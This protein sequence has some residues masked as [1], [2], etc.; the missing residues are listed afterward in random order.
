[1]VVPSSSSWTIPSAALGLL[2]PVVVLL[3]APA[4][5]ATTVPGGTIGAD[6]L[7][8]AT[9][10][11]YILGGDVTIG[12][13]ATLS[14]EA[15][16]VVLVDGT[17]TIQI[18]GGLDAAGSASQPISFL[19]NA[20]VARWGGLYFNA[21]SLPSSLSNVSLSAVT[22]GIW[23]ESP[24]ALVSLTDVSVDNAALWGID[25]HLVHGRLEA[26]HVTLTNSLE[27]IRLRTSDNITVADLTTVNMSGIWPPSRKSFLGINASE[28]SDSS[29]TGI[30]MN[31][32]SALFM[33]SAR[34]QISGI[35]GDRNFAPVSWAG[36]DVI[37]S[38]QFVIDDVDMKGYSDG[39]RLWEVTNSTA[40]DISVDSA[41]GTG[42][43]AT[44]S[45][46]IDNAT[47]TNSSLGV[48]AEAVWGG[49]ATVRNVHVL[50]SSLGFASYTLF[51]ISN[52][53]Y[54]YNVDFTVGNSVDNV[55]ILAYYRN[56]NPPPATTGPYSWLFVYGSTGVTVDARNLTSRGAPVAVWADVQGG[57]LVNLNYTG[58]LPGLAVANAS[59]LSLRNIYISTTRTRAF[60]AD[61][62]DRITVAGSTF[63]SYAAIPVEWTRV[64][65]STIENTSALRTDFSDV[66]SKAFIFD[67]CNGLY[68]AD[69][70][71]ASPTANELFSIDGN[72]MSFVRSTFLGN[73]TFGFRGS[74]NRLLF[75]SSQTRS[76]LA[77]DVSGADITVESSQILGALRSSGDRLHIIDSDFRLRR[78]FGSP[79]NGVI[80][81]GGSDVTIEDNRFVGVASG[82]EIRG[83]STYGPTDLRI[84]WNYFRDSSVGIETTI[85]GVVNVRNWIY[86]NEFYNNS[87]N[88]WDNGYSNG[89]TWHNPQ[90]LHGNFWDDYTGQDA[91]GD[92]IGDSPYTIGPGGAQDLY[93]LMRP[94][95][96][97][98]PTAR[99]DVPTVVDEDTNV[100]LDATNSTDDRAIVV[101]YWVI[102]DI[103]GPYTLTG[104][105]VP[106]TFHTPGSYRVEFFAFDSW[107]HSASQGADVAVRDRTPP[108]VASPV[109]ILWVD[110]D[111]DVSLT[112]A[113]TDNDPSWSF[114]AVFIWSFEGGWGDMN[115][116]FVTMGPTATVTFETPGEYQAVFTAADAAG[117]VAQTM[118]TV[119]VADVTSPT[120]DLIGNDNATLDEGTILTL[121]VVNLADNDPTFPGPG[122]VS[123]TVLDPGGNAT[124]SAS[125]A[126]TFLVGRPGDYTV[127]YSVQDP[128]GNS[129]GGSWS[130]V[131]LDA[132]PPT[133]QPPGN[134]IE[135][136]GVPFTLSA[137]GAFDW[138]GIVTSVWSIG[139]EEIG[140]DL[141]IDV[142]FDTPGTFELWLEL[143]D[144]L[145][146]TSAFELTVT[147]LDI[148]SPWPVEPSPVA[149][150]RVRQN[151]WLH[152]DAA[153]IFADNDPTF[154][155][156]GVFLWTTTV[157]DATWGSQRDHPLL[158]V[159]FPDVGDVVLTLEAWD[160]SHHRGGVEIRVR[161]VDGVPPTSLQWTRDPSDALTAGA[162]ANFS[163]SAVDAGAITYSWDFG[164]GTNGTGRAISH[165]YASA[166]NYSITLIAVDGFGNAASETFQVH[167][168]AAP[169]PAGRGPDTG[170]QDRGDAGDDGSLLG[171]LGLPA[172]LIIG[173]AA[174]AGVAATVL[175]SRRRRR[176]PP[177]PPAAPEAAERAEAQPTEAEYG[178][179][180]SYYE[181][182]YGPSSGQ[183]EPRRPGP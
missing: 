89:L 161:V 44:C 88:V 22:V 18:L 125:A 51:G 96:K 132:L 74:A 75:H 113:V 12:S 72:D 4:Q 35:T 56:V 9:G 61:A 62:S 129:V 151:E 49:Q 1:M 169:E 179:S 17:Y 66:G 137:E 43:F 121:E 50:N 27:G 95:D 57:S 153:A 150:L 176:E 174:A 106:F 108:V 85:P 154:P 143:A 23:L 178:D 6:Q 94:W 76:W 109:G 101:S 7:W 91:D 120:F 97:G 112:A 33:D 183:D 162:V 98:P 173:V 37:D 32:S 20:T 124:T 80:L 168:E 155:A 104:L 5:A 111:R 82:I 8:D 145:G 134:V 133:W 156:T 65:N 86:E 152:V 123:W 25:A 52:S 146:H 64:T 15:G 110:E 59:G 63:N 70:S 167:V 21:S 77:F 180:K 130:F 127:N 128:A 67:Y 170:G 166:G 3:V 119:R 138:S 139:G 58:G 141:S 47:V 38:D 87:Y 114:G 13:S 90:T 116:S 159:S 122:A 34:I 103:G 107:N 148:T 30:V 54:R 147:I 73:G 177:A 36:L 160:A 78:P 172:L 100:W 135:D 31:S 131:A 39:L 158:N 149:N 55:P 115:L 105:I 42:V 117:N 26:S 92:Y 163:A 84:R 41:Y 99:I 11:P 24:G 118:F 2:V 171:G 164:D 16:T 136:S 93:P 175:V 71:F 142:S 79:N 48:H 19:P 69:S 14:I 60:L 102:Y 53:L 140:S 40:T 29:F 81:Y 45:C 182:L 68:V 144:P 181:R 28:L 83:S 126:L 157:V 165:V 46:I 10:S